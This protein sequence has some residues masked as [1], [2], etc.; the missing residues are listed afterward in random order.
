MLLINTI[1]NSRKTGKRQ[2]NRPNHNRT[3]PMTKEKSQFRTLPEH[4]RKQILDLCST[5]P[6]DEV[7]TILARPR[8]HGMDISTSK[9]ALCRFFTTA[10]T[11]STQLLLAQTAAASQIQHEQNAN[12]FLAA[13]R[14][15]V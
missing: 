5:H 4:E 15:T 9:S 13:I 14:A 11:N 6:Y 3:A 12:A 2:P 7:V 1:V 8:P 10:Q